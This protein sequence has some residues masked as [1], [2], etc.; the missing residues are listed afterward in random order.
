MADIGHR[1][2]AHKAIKTYL[3]GLRSH[4]IDVDYSEVEVEV[5][6]HPTL[7]R[8]ATNIRKPTDIR[9][10]RGE[11]DMRER[12]PVTRDILPRLLRLLNQSTRH[13]ATSHAAFCL[14]FADFLRID[15]FTRA[16]SERDPDFNQWHL[17]R[18]SIVLLTDRLEVILPNP[19]T[20]YFRRGVILTILTTK[21]E[22]CTINSLGNLFRKHP[23]PLAD[24]L[25]YPG[26][27]CTRIDVTGPLKG[28]LL[29][30]KKMSNYFGHSFRRGA[31][32]SA[33]LAGMLT[34]KSS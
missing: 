5:F 11:A 22:E 14:V 19:R 20:D 7:E 18:G 24:P 27:A 32:A 30:L 3:S 12:K 15:E 10:P 31:A 29:L 26:F 2:L 16:N 23:A 4:H 33:R 9:K 6:H 1:R 17:T 34:P 13:G 21:D 8:V 25:F 28:L